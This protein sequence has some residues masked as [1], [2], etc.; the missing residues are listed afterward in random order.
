MND[1]PKDSG[2]K[3]NPALALL[4]AFTPSAVAMGLYYGVADHWLETARGL[5][6]MLASVIGFGCCLGASALLFRRKTLM[7]MIAGIVFMLLNA[8]ISVFF[9]CAIVINPE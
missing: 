7:A 5:V 3:Q 8:L 4:L 2:R 1:Q 6:L 9:G